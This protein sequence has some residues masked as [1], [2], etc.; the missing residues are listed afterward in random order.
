VNT[1]HRRQIFQ[2]IFEVVP[3]GLPLAYNKRIIGFLEEKLLLKKN[4]QEKD[5]TFYS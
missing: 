1:A 3:N 4:Y 5:F 2:K